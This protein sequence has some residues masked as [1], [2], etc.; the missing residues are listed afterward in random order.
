MLHRLIRPV[1][2]M[3]RD[4]EFCF[5][6][7]LPDRLLEHVRAHEMIADDDELTH[8]HLALNSAARARPGAF[9][10]ASACRR[11]TSCRTFAPAPHRAGF[12]VRAPDRPIARR[13]PPCS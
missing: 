2:I 9:A 4:V 5:R 7:F 10:H 6:A 11:G 12:R 13:N 3:A 1:E 8:D